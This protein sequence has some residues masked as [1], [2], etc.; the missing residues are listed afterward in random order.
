MVRKKKLKH[1]DTLD[2]FADLCLNIK[3][4]SLQRFHHVCVC[5]EFHVEGLFLLFRVGEFTQLTPSLYEYFCTRGP[6][7]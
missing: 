7:E 5:T 2:L 3:C 6:L 1:S 4:T